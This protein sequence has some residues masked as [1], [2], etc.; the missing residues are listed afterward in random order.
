MTK[1]L[2][3]RP[4]LPALMDCTV[5]YCSVL[6]FGMRGHVMRLFHC[7]DFSDISFARAQ[8]AIFFSLEHQFTQ[9]QLLL[10]SYNLCCS[11]S[12][13]AM[14]TQLFKTFQSDTAPLTQ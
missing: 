2:L 4:V 14:L 11:V 7:C 10:F 8:D 3:G 9:F 5:S 1:A 12:D 13:T 6:F